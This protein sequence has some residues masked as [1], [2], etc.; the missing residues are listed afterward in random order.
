MIEGKGARE[1]V[2]RVRFRVGKSWEWSAEERRGHEVR[3]SDGSKREEGDRK[4]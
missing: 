4:R 2:L 1:M 3:G